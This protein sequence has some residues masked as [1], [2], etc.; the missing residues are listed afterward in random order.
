ML[1]AG[2]AIRLRRIVSAGCVNETSVFAPAVTAIVPV[3]VEVQELTTLSES[4]RTS[5]VLRN[6]FL[7]LLY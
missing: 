2:I 1:P 7:Y 5:P 6:F 3:V 4:A